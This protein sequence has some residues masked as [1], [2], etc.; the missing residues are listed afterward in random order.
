[1]APSVVREFPLS[2]IMTGI[3]AFLSWNLI[4]RPLQ[5]VRARLR[6]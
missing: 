3:C 1:M 2:V 4:E 6:P 5:K